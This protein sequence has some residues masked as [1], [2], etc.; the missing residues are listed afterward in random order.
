MKSKELLKVI[1]NFFFFFFFFLRDFIFKKTIFEK[2]QHL[3]QEQIAK[4]KHMCRYGICLRKSP[5]TNICIQ[6]AILA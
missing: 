5:Y 6:L 1:A 2:P 3:K 4:L